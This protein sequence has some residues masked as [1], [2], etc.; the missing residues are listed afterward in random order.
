MSFVGGVLRGMCVCL[1]RGGWWC[2]C[3]E[4]IS[5]S[6][7]ERGFC[8]V[9]R[10]WRVEAQAPTCCSSPFLFICTNKLLPFTDIP[11]GSTFVFSPAPSCPD[12]GGPFTSLT[13]SLQ[14]HQ[15]GIRR[16]KTGDDAREISA[17]EV[18]PARRTA[19][20]RFPYAASVSAGR[21]ES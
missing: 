18:K 16:R 3:M 12:K 1:R 21:Q 14:R 15:G 10:G 11:Q 5:S 13:L 17:T 6:S 19:V 9:G 7:S 2:W 20:C 8:Q 4:L